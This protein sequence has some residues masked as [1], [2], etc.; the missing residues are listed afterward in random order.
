MH[1][2]GALKK[3]LDLEKVQ[4]KY[5]LKYWNTCSLIQSLSCEQLSG[6]NQP[7]FHMMIF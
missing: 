6:A 4:F 1:Q 3:W 5:D 2:N 7:I